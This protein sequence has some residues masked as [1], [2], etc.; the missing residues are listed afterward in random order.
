MRRAYLIQEPCQIRLTNFPTKIMSKKERRFVVSWYDEFD[1][2]EY[3]V[4]EDKAYCLFCYVCG[5]LM[6]QRGGRDA[7]ATQGF[8]TWSKKSA[9]RAHVGHVD[10]FHNRAREKCDFLVR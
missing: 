4:K 2:L 1:W 3:S 6:D 7:F 10:S 9:F 5:D 8:N